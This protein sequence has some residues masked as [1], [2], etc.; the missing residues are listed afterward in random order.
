VVRIRKKSIEE[1]C[2]ADD[3]PANRRPPA[4]YRHAAVAGKPHDVR[5]G[6][7]GDLAA[8]HLERDFTGYRH[9]F[10]GPQSNPG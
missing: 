3:R 7:A 6:H 10:V 4:L 1:L 5:R 2:D 8:H 9:G